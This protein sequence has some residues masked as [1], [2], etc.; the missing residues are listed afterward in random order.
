M[1]TWGWRSHFYGLVPLGWALQAAGHEVRVASHPVDGR[2]DQRGRARRRAAGRGLDFAEAFAG[3]IGAVAALAGDRARAVDAVE[4]AITADGGVV[5]F[6]DAV[7]DDLVSFGRAWRPD[8][9]LWEP[10]NLAAPVAA[11]A[12][13]VPGV[14]NL[15]GPDSSTTLRSTRSRW[16]GRSP[17]GSGRRRRCGRWT[18]C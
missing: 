13:G 18:A 10:F 3:R 8:L 9:M 4:P 14:L 15:W 16:S 2:R 6:A 11:A 12:L 17:A 7:L 5:R 1:S